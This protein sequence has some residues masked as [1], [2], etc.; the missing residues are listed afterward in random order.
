MI[1]IWFVVSADADTHQTANLLQSEMFSLSHAS[2]LAHLLLWRHWSFDRFDWQ[3]TSLDLM[4]GDV[5]L[6]G[7]HWLTVL[8]FWLTKWVHFCFA[9]SVP[10]LGF[11]TTKTGN[12]TCLFWGFH[13][14]LLAPY[15]VKKYSKSWHRPTHFADF[16]IG[17]HF[18]F[19]LLIMY[20]YLCI[21]SCSCLQRHTY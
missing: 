5:T 21:H 9:V 12:F 8:K 3:L 11:L 1:N 20:M 16:L 17:S 4:L 13:L 18:I 15:S 6:T 14:K 19:Y 10:S 7:A 2:S